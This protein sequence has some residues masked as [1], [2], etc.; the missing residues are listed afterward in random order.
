MKLRNCRIESHTT[1]AAALVAAVVGLAAFSGA[2]AATP[3]EPTPSNQALRTPAPLV[4]VSIP[5]KVVNGVGEP[6]PVVSQGTTTVAGAVTIQGTPTVNIASMPAQTL[7][8]VVGI[9]PAK[10]DVKVTNTVGVTG[11]VQIGNDASSPV[12]VGD[13]YQKAFVTSSYGTLVNGS[14]SIS[15]YSTPLPDGKRFVIEHVSLLAAVSSGRRPMFQIYL[16][17]GTGYSDYTTLYPAPS[18]LGV[19]GAG[20]TTD[21]WSAEPDVHVWTDLLGSWIPSLD[22]SGTIFAQV[23]L[24]GYLINK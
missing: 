3:P 7:S 21:Y 24:S 8:G 23:S 13:R 10:S 11:V 5:V 17:Q 15:G 19:F 9:D 1:R 6:I 22:G 2:R 20:A 18:F 16:L 12:V 4:T 14:G